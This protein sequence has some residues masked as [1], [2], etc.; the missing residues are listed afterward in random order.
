MLLNVGADCVG[1]CAFAD[2]GGGVH[3]R[4]SEESS[5]SF[6]MTRPVLGAGPACARALGR[7]EER[8]NRFIS[9][10]MELTHARNVQ[11][12]LLPFPLRGSVLARRRWLVAL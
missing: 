1:W 7:T 3:Q 10:S 4:E 9:P 12:G 5:E 8:Q 11:L 2:V 6:R